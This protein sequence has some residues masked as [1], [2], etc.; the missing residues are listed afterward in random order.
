MIQLIKKY[1]IPFAIGGSVLLIMGVR[2]FSTVG[3]KVGSLLGDDS[4]KE[5]KEI[6]GILKGIQKDI[7]NGQTTEYSDEQFEQGAKE[8]EIAMKGFGADVKAI[9][10]VFD[11]INNPLEVRKL[12]SAFGVRENDNLIQWLQYNLVEPVF[13]QTKKGLFFTGDSLTALGVAR[14]ILARNNV[15][16]AL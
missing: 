16:F 12:I 10:K 5:Q 7:D 4:K 14:D 1:P 8:L 15:K 6:D 11:N 2:T 3:D 9:V 13:V